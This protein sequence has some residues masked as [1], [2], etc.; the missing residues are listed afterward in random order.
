MCAKKRNSIDIN[1]LVRRNV[2]TMKPY[3]S[4]RDEFHGDAEIFLDANEKR[5]AEEGYGYDPSIPKFIE[6]L[7]NVK[8]EYQKRLK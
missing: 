5:L 4:A 3:S 6:L 7:D 2:L 8:A 1:T